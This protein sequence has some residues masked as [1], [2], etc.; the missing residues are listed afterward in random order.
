MTPSDDLF[1]ADDLELLPLPDA[2]VRFMHK[3]ALPISES[4]LLERLVAEVPWKAEQVT[5]WG[6]VHAQPRLIAWYGDQGRTYSY[7]GISMKPLP[8]SPLLGA[9]RES[10]Q[11]ATRESFNSVLLNFYRDGRDSMGF[12]SDDEKE[13]G[14]TPVIASLSLGETR[15]F[16]FKHKTSKLLKPVR[17]P[18]PSASLLVMRGATQQNWKHGIEKEARQC[19]P[20]VNLTF[21]QILS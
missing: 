15:T 13:L 20:R 1:S 5:V 17:V 4:E 8:W 21:R 18:L 11:A 7:S 9:V 14:K 2:D 3:L 12:H 6:K 10:V 19:G 16:V